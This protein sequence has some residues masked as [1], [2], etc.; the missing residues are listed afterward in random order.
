MQTLTNFITHTNAQKEPCLAIAKDETELKEFIKILK[1][2]KFKNSKDIFSLLKAIKSPCDNYFV[3][4]ENEKEYKNIYDFIVQYPMNQIQ[5][6]DKNNNKIIVNPN[7]Q[8]ISLIFLITKDN[9]LKMQKQGFNIL[10]KTGI[11]F[12]S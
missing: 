3:I 9:L 6:M 8:D 7:Y 12:Q 10:N 4:S 2:Q 11:T 5:M 1:N